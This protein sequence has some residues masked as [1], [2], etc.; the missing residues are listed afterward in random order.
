MPQSVRKLLLADVRKAFLLHV[1]LLIF[2]LI[3]RINEVG[4]GYGSSENW[5]TD[6]KS[7]H[8]VEG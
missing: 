3:T 6:D 4:F 8:E 7:K 1:F 2:G 5:G